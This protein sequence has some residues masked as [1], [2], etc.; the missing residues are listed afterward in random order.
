MLRDFGY[1]VL[2]PMLSKD[3]M[4]NELEFRATGYK[5][6]STTNHAIF[7]RDK[8]M[9]KSCDILYANLWGAGSRTSIGCMME[10][11]WASAFGKHI[12]LTMPMDDNPHQHAFVLEAAHVYYE[13]ETAA[14]DYLKRLAPCNL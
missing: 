14:E 12:V 5:G 1:T 4:R 9:V 7:E 13:F 6:P 11:A 10:M 2:S 3:E 8:W